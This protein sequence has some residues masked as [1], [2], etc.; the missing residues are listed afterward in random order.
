MMAADSLATHNGR[1]S[2]ARK[3]F[4]VRGA[5]IGISGDLHAGLAFVQWAREGGKGTAPSGDYEALVL[6]PDGKIVL[7]I[8]PKVGPVNE[9]CYAIGTGADCAMAAMY[10]GRRPDEAV[11]IASRIDLHT[12]G[13][14]RVYRRQKKARAKAGS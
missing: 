12:G 13:R 14:V 3:L 2:S 7:Y 9:A 5:I 4:R 1:R 11:R 8:G 10:C 6:Q